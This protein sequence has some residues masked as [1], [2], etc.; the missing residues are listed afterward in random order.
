MGM[1]ALLAFELPSLGRW[2]QLLR[3]T[4]LSNSRYQSKNAKALIC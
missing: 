4:H 3:Q 2:V 1:Y